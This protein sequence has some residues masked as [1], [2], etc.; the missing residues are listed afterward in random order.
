MAER[1]Y[2]EAFKWE[3]HY[4][5][6]KIC[7]C[8]Y[9]SFSTIFLVQTVYNLFLIYMIT[10]QCSSTQAMVH[11]PSQDFS[12]YLVKIYSDV[13]MWWQIL[14][15]KLLFSVKF[16]LPIWNVHILCTIKSN[17]PR[18]SWC[19]VGHWLHFPCCCVSFAVQS[20][21]AMYSLLSFTGLLEKP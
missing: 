1:W 20:H 16:M 2:F 3:K 17:I 19:A 13:C 6:D 21:K 7:N 14:S 11:F 15:W 9:L 8:P 5:S 10:V 12:K 4:H 18:V